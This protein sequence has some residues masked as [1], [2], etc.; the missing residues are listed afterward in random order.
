MFLVVMLEGD[1]QV[2]QGGCSVVLGHVADVI[3]L[4]GLHEALRHAVDL[5]AAH[6]GGQAQQAD[7]PGKGTG[8]LGGISR[9]VGAQPLHRRYRSFIAK[10]LLEASSITARTSSP[11]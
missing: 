9:A 10:A 6:R 4:N 2:A 7:L 8:L 5:Q 11:L 1:G 3:A